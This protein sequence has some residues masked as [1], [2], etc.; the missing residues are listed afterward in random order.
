MLIVHRTGVKPVLPKVPA[1]ETP[2][3]PVLR[4]AAM[5]AAQA[6]GQRVRFLRDGDQMY[7][8][9]HQ[10]ISENPDVRLAA[11][12]SEQFQ[13]D[14]AVLFGVKNALAVGAALGDM[15]RKAGNNA[16]GNSGHM[17]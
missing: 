6:D 1:A 17:P 12:F 3:V 5:R 11:I 8:V 13:V 14:A 4:I 9:E 7:V 16:A 2:D 15:V 10:A